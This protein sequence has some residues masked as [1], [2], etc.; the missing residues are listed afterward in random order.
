MLWTDKA[1][2]IL[3]KYFDFAT[4][5]DKQIDVIN[6][7]LKGNDVV[8]L[9]PTGYG[10]SMCYILP[11]LLTKKIIFIVSPL[12][13]LMDDQKENLSLKG[14]TVAT[15]HG[16]NKNRQNEILEIC[17]GNIKIVYM[18]PEFLVEG[19]GLALA[20]NLVDNNLLGFLAIDES[21]CLSSWG[22]D[23]RPNYLLLKEFRS[24]FPKI[25]I[26]AVTATA[27]KAVVTDICN[28]LNL[29]SPKVISAN[30]DRPNLFLGCKEIPKDFK[31]SA[32]GTILK[33]KGEP[34]MT[35][36]S[37]WSII[38]NYINKYPN[39]RII[40]YVGSRNDTQELA[41][42]INMYISE[43]AVAYHAGLSKNTR[44]TV[45]SSFIDGSIKVI[46]STIAFGMGI[47]QIVRC[48]IVFGCPSSIEGYYQESGRAGR[49]GLPSE[50]YL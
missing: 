34:I 3:K 38:K 37:K 23:F 44:E 2:K 46:V 15:L 20:N 35:N 13:S 25:P 41:D 50:T 30:F 47:D 48:V 9:L 8:G 19:D 24:L 17:E 31:R 43:C 10:K 18:S 36:I 14:I 49:D 29:N 39:D 42:D 1:L 45:Q 7:L 27:K 21:H 40:I 28:F 5:K 6:E 32:K 33:K 22:H 16:N 11:P 12:I 4:L 26:L